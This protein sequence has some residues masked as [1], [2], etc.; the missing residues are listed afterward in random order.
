MRRD[1]KNKIMLWFV[2]Y[3]FLLDFKKNKEHHGRSPIVL[4]YV[5]R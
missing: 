3:I 2:A 1:E 5:K 4:K